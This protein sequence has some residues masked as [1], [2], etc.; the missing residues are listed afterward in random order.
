MPSNIESIL[1]KSAIPAEAD[2]LPGRS[3]PLK[4][5]GI[6][7]VNKE[8]FIRSEKP[9]ESEIILGMGCFW[10]AER[11]L[12]NTPG[13]IVTSVGYAGGFTSNPTYE[14]VC[15]GQTGHSEVVQVV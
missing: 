3:T 14:E 5:S 2:A 8:P 7:A 11:K 1:K 9:N 12:W 10:G 6:H 13:V 15:S 4:I